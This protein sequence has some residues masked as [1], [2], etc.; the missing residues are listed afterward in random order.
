ME[1]IAKCPHFSGI[2]DLYWVLSPYFILSTDDIRS[3]ASEASGCK[4]ERHLV[5]LLRRLVNFSATIDFANLL[6]SNINGIYQRRAQR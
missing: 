4:A 5:C 3:P 6:M 1:D 2:I